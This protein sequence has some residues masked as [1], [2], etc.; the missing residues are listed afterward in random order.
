MIIK[1]ENAPDM[2]VIGARF[3]EEKLVVDHIQ[4]LE[5]ILRDLQLR[6]KY[7]NEGGFSKDRTMRY[8]GTIPSSATAINPELAKNAEAALEFLENE[9]S[10]FRV[11]KTDT[12]RSGHIIIK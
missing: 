3:E 2:G 11:N 10:Q 7:Q 8:I 1:D 12:G 4:D 5:P 9:G 6:K